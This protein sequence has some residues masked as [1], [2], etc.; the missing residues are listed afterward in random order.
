MLTCHLPL[1]IAFPE[2]LW[3]RECLLLLTRECLLLLIRECLLLLTRGCLLIS[4]HRNSPWLNHMTLT[5]TFN[6]LRPS[7]KDRNRSKL[8]LEKCG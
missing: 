7:K 6:A 1:K 3:F 4:S 2:C 5:M 8:D